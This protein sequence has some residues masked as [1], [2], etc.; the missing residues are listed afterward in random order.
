MAKYQNGPTIHFTPIAQTYMQNYMQEQLNASAFLRS[1]PNQHQTPARPTQQV[2]Q[3][4]QQPTR[5][6]YAH[7]TP[8]ATST[9]TTNY[10]QHP[11]QNHSQTKRIELLPP[12]KEHYCTLGPEWQ[13]WPDHG[14]LAV[15]R[16]RSPRRWLRLAKRRSTCAPAVSRPTL[17]RNRHESD[18]GSRDADTRRGLSASPARPSPRAAASG[19]PSG[20][21]A[22]PRLLL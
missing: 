14:R 8:T 3:T 19:Q 9:P 15:C 10:A 16:G 12:L 17:A 5:A 13:A 6:P 22:S 1:M 20:A 21:A 2:D 7:P 11:S 4:L 18:E